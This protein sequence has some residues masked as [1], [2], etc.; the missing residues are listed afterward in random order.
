MKQLMLGLALLSLEA[1]GQQ[2]QYK[3]AAIAQANL[4]VSL[5]KQSKYREAVEAYRRA[6]DIDPTLPN[7]NLNIGLAW[8]KL[9]DFRQAIAAFQKEPSNDR[10]ATLIGMSYF[11]L[12]RY[13]EA[14]ARLKPLADAQPD[15]SELA[16]LLAKCYLWS[17]ESDAGMALFQKMLE[18]DPDSVATH[19]LLGEALDAQNHT[20]DAI[21]EFEVAAKNGPGQPEV[22]FGLGYLYWKQKRYEEAGREFN[23]ELKTNPTHGMA[24]AYA[25]DIALRAGND[26]QALTLLKKAIDVQK[27]IHLAHLDL[28]TV[29][30]QEKRNEQAVAEFRESI[31]IDPSGFDGHYRL[32]R[33]LKEMGRKAEA[34]KEFA[35]VQNL[36]EKKTAEPLLRISGPR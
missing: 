7:I 16:Y 2:Q 15:N 9:G 19:M 36:H 25:G 28:G 23:L 22:H 24:L 1:L 8:F 5:A 30:Q 20:E 4:G 33:L 29:Y 21:R 11:G 26:E 3:P 27:D 6:A 32:A 14:A 18:R 10:V 12:A 35:I 34:D 31:R 13:K 17:G